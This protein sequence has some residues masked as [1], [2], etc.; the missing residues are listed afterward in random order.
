MPPKKL[1]WRYSR[2]HPGIKRH[3]VAPRKDGTVC[4]RAGA[5]P[6]LADTP[7]DITCETCLLWYQSGFYKE[8]AGPQAWRQR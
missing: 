7:E 5:A 8:Y 4:G 1:H 3:H 6:L 2:L